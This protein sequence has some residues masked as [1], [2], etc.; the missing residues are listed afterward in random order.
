MF[1]DVGFCNAYAIL[2]IIPHPFKLIHNLPELFAMCIELGVYVRLFL[3]Y[4]SPSIDVVIAHL[5]MTFD[6]RL[7]I[8][9][10]IL[11]YGAYHHYRFI[12][13]IRFGSTIHFNGPVPKKMHAC[14]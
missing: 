6:L 8:V 7:L 11:M 13:V 9:Y 4:M 5:S 3:S 12:Y 1:L 14:L 10:D 2:V